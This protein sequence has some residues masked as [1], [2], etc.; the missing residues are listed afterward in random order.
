MTGVNSNSIELRENNTTPDNPASGV[1]LYVKPDGNI[2]VRETAGNEIN[3]TSNVNTLNDLTN[4]AISLPANGHVLRYNGTNWVNYEL[5]TN[6]NSITELTDTD[7]VTPSDNTVLVYYGTDF[8]PKIKFPGMIST[9]LSVGQ[10]VPSSPTDAERSLLATGTNIT[11]SG[12]TTTLLGSKYFY[13]YSDSDYTD[14]GPYTLYAFLQLTIASGTG[15]ISIEPV[16]YDTN[17]DIATAYPISSYTSPIDEIGL[18]SST[19]TYWSGFFTFSPETDTSE[20]TIAITNTT[21]QDV[22]VKY[23]LAWQKTGNI[24]ST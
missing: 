19:T 12:D 10:T 17:T 4:V 14:R 6:I 15:N 24:V 20:Y 11:S 23:S 22:N 3:I 8:K 16:K 7:I 1:I 13:L 5:P 18:D 21:G 2:Y 9:N